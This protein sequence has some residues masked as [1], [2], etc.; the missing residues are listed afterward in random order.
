MNKTEILVVGNKTETVEKTVGMLN[1]CDEWSGIEALTDEDAVTKF[2]Q[3][4]IDVV[5]LE[6]DITDVQERKLR[7]LFSFQNPD[8]VITR[9]ESDD[10]GTLHTTINDILEKKKAGKKFSFVMIDDAL[11]NAGLNIQ[12]Q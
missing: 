6:K 7:K 1:D 8:V 2:Q 10:E 12:V 11:K 4:Q 5:L 3:Y 9:V